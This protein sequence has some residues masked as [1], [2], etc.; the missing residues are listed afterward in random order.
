MKNEITL[1]DI[2]DLLKKRNCSLPEEIDKFSGYFITAATIATA[3]AATTPVAALGALLAGAGAAN[4]RISKLLAWLP[5]GLKYPFQGREIVA[6]DRYELMQVANFM[7]YDIA[8]KDSFEQ[9]V[10]PFI[11]RAIYEFKMSICVDRIRLLTEDDIESKKLCDQ[12]KYRP[13]LVEDTR[14]ALS[15]I[16]PV[17]SWIDNNEPENDEIWSIYKEVEHKYIEKMSELYNAYLVNLSSQFPEFLLFFDL[18]HKERT[19]EILS[20]IDGSTLENTKLLQKQIKLL[21]ELK[22]SGKSGFEQFEKLYKN[23]FQRQTE[24]IVAKLD[25]KNKKILE[26][27]HRYIA[28]QTNEILIDNQD[29]EEIVYPANKDIFIPQGYQKI[30]Y[31]KKEHGYNFLAPSF[32]DEIEQ[33]NDIEAFLLKTLINPD[34]AD[35]PI[36]ILGNPGAGKSMLSKILAGK[37]AETPDFVPFFV[38]LRE[39]ATSSKDV[40]QH[41][42]DGIAKSIGRP[43][44]IDWMDL[45][46]SI[47]TRYPVIILDGFDELIQSS[48]TE[49]NEY[50]FEIM[51]FQKVAQL[52]DIC[53]RVILTSRLSVMNV[54][55]IPDHTNIIKLAPF[56]VVRRDLWVETW[57][58]VQTKK[59]YSLNIP[60]KD[61]VTELAQEPL[62]LI[63]LAVYDFEDSGLQNINNDSDFNQSKLYDTLLT[64]FTE[65]QLQKKSKSYRSMVNC[66]KEKEKELFRLRLGMIAFTMFLSD[67]TSLDDR[68]LSAKLEVFGLNEYRVEET[69]ILGGFFF[70]RENKTVSSSHEEHHNYEFLHKT[71]GEFL[72]ADFLLRIAINQFSSTMKI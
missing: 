11:K 12:I 42:N 5:G 21:E 57:N 60:E 55:E 1:S 49:L 36:L 61:I 45:T 8:I 56:D 68:H 4:F 39:V 41:V 65:R 40:L 58:K 46:E 15:I 54:V 69:D 3:L 64:K 43:G 59:D 37:L 31:I 29:I 63:M 71:F 17:G 32:W 66:K 67:T 70:V 9:I 7:L 13:N 44:S 20:E 47:S 33:R 16:S 72:V 6:T 14:F 48:K 62:L 22:F 51:E 23:L 34:S 52:N 53:V 26:T 27:H 30:R 18:E 24:Q 50:L 25:D 35:N 38:K 2:S 19:L 28:S 10:Y